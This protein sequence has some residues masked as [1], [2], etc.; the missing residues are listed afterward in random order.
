M[1][2]GRLAAAFLLAA[3]WQGAACAQS[4]QGVGPVGVSAPGGA[5]A[6]T[7]PNV[8]LACGQDGTAAIQA[9]LTAG[10]NGNGITTVT[11][12]PC[13]AS[14]PI[15]I[16]ATLLQS[17]NTFLVCMEGTWLSGAHLAPFLENTN[18]AGGA[19]QLD[20]Q[21]GVK[22]CNFN[23]QG[24]G[25]G[26]AQRG[27][28][29]LG[30][31]HIWIEHVQLW[32]CTSDCLYVDGNAAQVGN[33][34]IDDVLA[35]GSSAG[36]GFYITH[37]LR[38]MKMSNLHSIATANNGFFIDHSQ[39][40]YVNLFA[41]GAGTG[42][43]CANSG[44]ST[45]DNPGG[46]STSQSTWSPCPSG[47]FV[48]NVTNITGGV[49]QATGNQYDGVTIIGARDSNIGVIVAT[50]NSLNA[51]GTWDD[52]HLDL[53]NTL[54][55]GYGESANLAIGAVVAGANG[56]TAVGGANSPSPATSRYGVRL[57]PGLAGSCGGYT[58]AVA[59]TGYTVGDNAS[60]ATSPGSETQNCKVSVAAVSG[61]ST[62]PVT[63][64]TQNTTNG[65]GVWTKLPPNPVSTTGGTGSG[66][67]LNVAW[68]SGSVGP[69][70]C[71]QTISGCVSRP[72]FMQ[73]WNVQEFSSTAPANNPFC[74]AVIT[75]A[76]TIAPAGCG[77]MSGGA[78]APPSWITA[79]TWADI[80]AIG[81]GGGGGY[82]NTA[83]EAGGAGGAAGVAEGLGTGLVLPGG[84]YA[85]TGPG[86]AGAAGTNGVAA[87]AGTATVIALETETLTANGGA[88]GGVCNGAF[89]SNAGGTAS[90]GQINRPGMAGTSSASGVNSIGGDVAFGFGSSGKNVGSGG[91]LASVAGTGYGAAGSGALV[92]G[93]NG[94]AGTQGA[95]FVSLGGG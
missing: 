48:R 44:T 70:T 14:N 32:N 55:A 85:V 89:Q 59:G 52:L 57:A 30:V 83:A 49:W 34:H 23:F 35:D 8:S 51:T 80:A 31:N 33:G 71:G 56:Q 12:P 1:I 73:Y 77:T 62:G 20:D 21:V 90:G 16:S 3:I 5:G 41:E 26:S 36:A 43:S 63:S 81:G 6:Y 22:N 66:L 4:P 7:L 91:A 27:I 87:T 13:P 45:V 65:S 88:A 17:S 38:G 15:I 74:R 93:G 68:S 69:V 79:N 54:A 28:Y 47:I 92:T 40:D 86:S 25:A 72:S 78:Y 95:V 53:N 2:P 10:G 11:P 29:Y 46:G 42:S 64:V 50:N 19:G 18:H 67:T 37:A 61:G 39:G 84:S 24:S 60:L 76:S 75:G 9:A 94:G 82:C 58:I